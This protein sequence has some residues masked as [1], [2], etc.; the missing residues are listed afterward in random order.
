MLKNHGKMR[1]INW[2]LFI[3]YFALLSCILNEKKMYGAYMAIQKI[4]HITEPGGKQNVF[5]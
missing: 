3:Y 4:K 1:R 2:V 5:K